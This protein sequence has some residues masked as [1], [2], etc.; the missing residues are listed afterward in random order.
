MR[1]TM[2]THYMSIQL[3]KAEGA[4]GVRV[5]CPL[6]PSRVMDLLRNALGRMGFPFLS[7]GSAGF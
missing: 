3:K 1:R 6:R 5:E 4:Q 2:H 7:I